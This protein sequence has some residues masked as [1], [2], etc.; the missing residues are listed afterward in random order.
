MTDRQVLI[1]PYRPQDRHEAM[2]LASRLE[3]GVAPW[4]DP[5]AVRAAVAGWV[6]GS[7]DS[8]AA[9][10][11]QVFV[12]IDSSRVVGVVTVGQR[13]HFTGETDAYVGELV[14]AEGMERRG[15]GTQLMRAAEEWGRQRG[16]KHLTLETG[17]ANS[18][19]RAFYASLQYEEE[20]VRLTKK[21]D[22]R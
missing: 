20:D 10:N 6:R 4:R 16:L 21:L 5:A 9:E 18:R 17:A 15:V 2:S 1:R 11:R 8:C 3:I 14:V 7:L 13:Q 19:A 22:G 12:A